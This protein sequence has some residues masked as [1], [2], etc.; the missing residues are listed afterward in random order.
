MGAASGAPAITIFV[1]RD[2]AWDVNESA[3]LE[4]VTTHVVARVVCST[5]P[6]IEHP[7]VEVV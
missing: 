2:V 7:V 6:V 1:A 5:D 4:A 3:V